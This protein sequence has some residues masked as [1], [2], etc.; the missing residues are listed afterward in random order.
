MKTKKD[1]ENELDASGYKLFRITDGGSKSGYCLYDKE[2]TKYVATINI[3]NCAISFNGKDYTETDAL[4]SDI[5][6]YN[7]GLYFDADTYCP[8]YNPSYVREMRL[9]SVLKKCGFVNDKLGGYP[10]PDDFINEGVL[11]AMFGKILCRQTL[12][13]GELSYVSLYDDNMDDK[14]AAESVRSIIA[15]M[16]AANVAKLVGHLNDMGSIGKIDDI[17]VKTIN[18]DTYQITTSSGK[19]GIIRLLED[20]LKKLKADTCAKPNE[21]ENNLSE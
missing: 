5:K 16:Y 10:S 19:E 1:F 2:S 14:T 18:P 11:G 12:S 4:L 17:E 6:E 8:N 15:A 3:H 9:G 7:D 20:T 13:V 21:V